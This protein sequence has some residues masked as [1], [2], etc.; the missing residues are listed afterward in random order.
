[1]DS[2]SSKKRESHVSPVITRRQFATDALRR[3]QAQDGMTLLIEGLAGMGKT[4]LLRELVDAVNQE[5]NWQVMVARADEIESGEPYSFIE[6]LVASSLIPDWHFVP[7]A[8]TNPVSVARECIRRLVTDAEPRDR[9]IVIDDAHWIDV[10]SQ[11]VLRYLIPRITRRKILLAIGIRTPHEPDSFGEFLTRLV[12]DSPLDELYQV[13]PLTP[14]EVVSLTLD[15]VGVAISLYTAQGLID[16]A[17]GSFLGM[18]SML[19]ALTSAEIAQLHLAWDAPVR[20]PI[21]DTDPLLHQF[22]QLSPDAQRTCELVCLAG[23][24]LTR[25]DLAAAAQLLGEP[26]ALDEAIRRE[27]LFESRFSATITSRHALLSQA[28]SDKVTA[29]RSRAVFAALAVV[30][31]GYRSLHHTLLGA[32]QW[33]EDLRE[34]V[35]AFVHTAVEKGNFNLASDL[36][37]AA[38]GLASQPDSRMELI[39]SLVLLHIRTKTGYLV[40]DLLDEV[41]QFSPSVLHE[42]MYIVGS[43]H[44]VGQAILMERAQRL[45]ATPTDDPDE[46][47]IIAFFAFMAV[48]L[49]MRTMDRNMVS[50]LIENAKIL[51]QRGP[52]DINELSDHRL[53]W[54]VDKEAFLLVLDCYLMVQNQIVAKMDEVTRVIPNLTRRIKELPDNPLKVDALVAVAGAQLALGHVKEGQAL[55]QQGVELLERVDEPWAGSTVRLILA[56]TFVLQGRFTQATDLMELA[57]QVTYRSLDVET[58]STWA[59]LRVI[60]AAITNPEEATAHVEQARRIQEITWEAYGPDFS[61][62][63]DCELARVQGDYAAVLR[64]SS[65]DRAKRVANSRHGFLTY[66]AHALIETAQFDEAALL[67]AQLA[68]W[69]GTRW[70]EYWGSLDWL[71]ARLAQG[72]G[73]DQ[74]AQW[75][76]EA[77]I[78][79]QDFPLPLGLTL[80]DF[81]NFLILS[82]DAERG[83]QMLHS[84]IQVLEG[85][86]AEGYLPKIRQAV[87]V[88]P[89][90]QLGHDREKA[91][92][93]L[94][95]RERQITEHLAK[96]RSNNQIA[97]SL[98]VSVTTVR[99]HVS[100]VLRK[101]QL[102]SRGEI[103][104]L[105]RADPDAHD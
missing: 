103:A 30:T 74:T 79:N 36:L 105:L 14:Q 38:L 12:T 28:V 89:G 50:P 99:S 78:E 44:K 59:A 2:K 8:Q 65:S 45:L 97:E 93:T 62:L 42:F 11:R 25:E 90:E 85:I 76:Y 73:D 100:N 87:L 3:A 4:Y 16:V 33:D 70:Q 5:G 27:V 19:A 52:S 35:N 46:R 91:L 80:A 22:K 104:R 72:T 31:T 58:R 69:R 18:D 24:E 37:R 17:G 66:R 54:M 96:G 20:V 88:K 56:D 7:D 68:E 40:L 48:I 92:S 81:G 64:T 26:V 71:R 23:H 13:E 101:L 67:I 94:T 1:M 84:S 32:E 53:G 86:G 6:R 39:E 29:E 49:T 51:I 57:E 41:E 43:A 9:V 21:G 77:A 10:E 34:Q 95:N 61:L 15:R 47:A 75:Y 98:V 83:A 102:S 82:G 63:A 60:I 55:A